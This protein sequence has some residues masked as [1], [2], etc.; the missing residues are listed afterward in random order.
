MCGRFTNRLTWREIVA[1]YRLTVPAT[2]ERNLPARYNICARSPRQSCCV[3]ELRDTTTRHV[4]DAHVC[5][6]TGGNGINRTDPRTDERS[7]RSLI[8]RSIP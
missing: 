2:P 5:L 6:V 4:A 8:R 7:A 3:R 1:L